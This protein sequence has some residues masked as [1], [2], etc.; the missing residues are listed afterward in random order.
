ME[1]H[2]PV[3]S[4]RRD[5]AIYSFLQC[6]AIHDL[7]LAPPAVRKDL[8]D[9]RRHNGALRRA[10][11]ALLADPLTRSIL[12]TTQAVDLVKGGVKINA[13]PE[14]VKAVVNYRIDTE[15]YVPPR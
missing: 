11:R 13:L 14:T 15:R 3:A 12:G 7:P 2:A 1:E 9:S 8:L 10:E 5:S 6:V 4:L